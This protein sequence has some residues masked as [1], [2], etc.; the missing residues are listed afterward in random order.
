MSAMVR[1]DDIVFGDAE[2]DLAWRRLREAVEAMSNWTVTGNVVFEADPQTGFQLHIKNPRVSMSGVVAAGGISAQSGTTFGSG[3]VDIV[4]RRGDQ[5][6][7]G[8]TTVCYSNMPV[9][10]EAGTRV[11]VEPD[12]EA[13][14]IVTAHCVPT[15]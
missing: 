5:I 8:Y 7:S 13:Y 10:L 4:F 12:G 1:L 14:K 3:N 6:L 15:I 11:E 2:L 9:V